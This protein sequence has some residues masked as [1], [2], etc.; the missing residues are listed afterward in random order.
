VLTQLPADFPGIAI[1][2][3]MPEHFT[4]AFARRLDGLCRLRVSEARDGDRVLPGHALLAP[5]SSHMEVMRSGADYAV[6]VFRGEP[7]NH[8][9][10]SVD[11]L[12]HS[13]AASTGANAVGVIMTGMG[14]D[15]A[16]GLLAMR[17]AGARTI[18]QDESTSV[19]FG[20][21]KEAIAVGAAECVE[22]LPLI[23]AALQ[24]VLRRG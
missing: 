10:P 2:Q 23:S 5:G 15:G 17:K 12:F 9:R 24:R 19:V 6:R 13:C 8:H 14:G 4:S 16:R 7:V 20:M 3:H 22:P 21:P 11:V 1:V 18:A